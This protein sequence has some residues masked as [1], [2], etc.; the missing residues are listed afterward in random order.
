MSSIW[1]SFS[2]SYS[3]VFI[4]LALCANFCWQYLA[5][6]FSNH[7]LHTL[8][9]ACFVKRFS[10]LFLHLHF[11]CITQ[12]AFSS[13]IVGY[14]TFFSSFDKHEYAFSP[15]IHF[16]TLPLT[17]SACLGCYLMTILMMHKNMSIREESMTHKL[18][19]QPIT[20]FTERFQNS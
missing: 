4:T 16:N 18:T 14:S 5:Q 2:L 8:I 1:Y 11:F 10:F 20:K 9:S 7:K 6:Y 13:F 12:N 15:N 3:L 17:L 19:F